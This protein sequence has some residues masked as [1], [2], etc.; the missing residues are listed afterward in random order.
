MSRSHDVVQ[1]TSWLPL[2]RAAAI[3]WVPLARQ[4][5]PKPVI[6]KN[7]T[8][9]LSHHSAFDGKAIINVSGR[10]FEILK[11]NLDRYPHTLLGSDERD[12][13]YDDSRGEYYF[14]RDPEIF[15][16]ILSYYRCGH[17]H[18]PKQECVLAY[19]DELTYFRIAPDVM[20]DCCYEDY[21]DGKRENTER[22]LD[23]KA[24]VEKAAEL[25][26]TFR[27]RLWFEFEN[28]EVS[29]SAIVIYYVTGFFI[30]ISV[31]ANVF[32]TVPCGRKPGTNESP[33][34]GDQ[35]SGA[36]FCMDTACVIIFTL[37]YCARLYAAPNRWKFFHSVM[38][39][40]DVV[41]ILPFYIGLVM[42]NN[43][44]ICKF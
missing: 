23:E 7:F 38:S 33:P 37:E 40:I 24:S 36:F 8:S 3:G 17:L 44:V 12:Y 26:K 6:S 18:Y 42:P 19:D 5:L 10:R 1:I 22:I 14:D 41:A 4:R 34:C 16:H 27:A 28:P 21:Q 32:E 11:S 29:T 25:P 39:L 15:R 35:Y 31:M 30:A 2:A 20:G 9:E 13:F 43:K